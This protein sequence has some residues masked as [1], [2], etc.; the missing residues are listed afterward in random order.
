METQQEDTTITLEDGSEFIAENHAV[1]TDTAADGTETVAEMTVSASSDDPSRV[2]GY[3]IVTE[4]APD[5]TQTVTEFVGD[6]NGQFQVEPESEFEQVIEAAFGIEIPDELTPVVLPDD[7]QSGDNSNTDFGHH[8]NPV[9]TGSAHYTSGSYE[10]SGEENTVPFEASAV[11]GYETGGTGSNFDDLYSVNAGPD[12][13]YTSAIT[14]DQTDAEYT[15][16]YNADWQSYEQDQANVAHETM[17]DYAAH[18]DYDAANVYAQSAD[19]HQSAADDWNNA[20][21]E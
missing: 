12:I 18:G 13:D 5:G 16:E 17:V 6:E 9:E 4:T 19:N 14:G 21:D 11:G 15:A 10:M 3:M 1:V 8:D 20:S 2:E 7:A